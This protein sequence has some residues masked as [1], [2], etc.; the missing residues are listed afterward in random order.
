MSFWTNSPSY[1]N[2]PIIFLII[3]DIVILYFIFS[4]LGK[5][6]KS[7]KDVQSIKNVPNHGNV[8]MTINLGGSKKVYNISIDIQKKIQELTQLDPN[9]LGFVDQ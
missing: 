3:V 4:F 9:N 5:T 2:Y 8:N 6:T 7:V 1:M